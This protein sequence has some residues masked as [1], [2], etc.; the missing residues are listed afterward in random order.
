[1]AVDVSAFVPPPYRPPAVPGLVTVTC[2]I[3]AVATADAGT[4]ALSWVESM[5]VGWMT[6]VPKLTVAFELNLVPSISS[7]NAWAPAFMF[8]GVSWV[9]TGTVPGVAGVVDFEL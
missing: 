6:V 5:N 9:I 7:G 3:P 4:V 8:G 2:T 1:M